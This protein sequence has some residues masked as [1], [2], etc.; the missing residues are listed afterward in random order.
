MGTEWAERVHRVMMGTVDQIQRGETEHAFGDID[1][2]LADALHDNQELWI[3]TL[4]KHAAVMAHAAGDRDREIRY[5]K[6]ALPFATDRQFALYNLA[7]LLQRDGQIGAAEQYAT[8]AYQLSVAE[9]T[10]D[11]RELSAAILRLW[12]SIAGR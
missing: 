12:P 5:T 7:E 9:G 8:E 11:N 10:A 3:K 6:Q 1:R 4:C 2:T